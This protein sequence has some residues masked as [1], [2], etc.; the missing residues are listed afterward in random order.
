MEYKA[1]LKRSNSHTVEFQL[2]DELDIEEVK[3]H[4]HNGRIYAH[5]DFYD[6]D[7]I[8]N[9]QR[10]HLYAL[11]KDIEDYTGTPVDAVEAYQKYLFMQHEDLEELP[12][13]AR[14]KMT[15]VVA[16]HFLEF[17]IN[18]CI[19]NGI[20][21]RQQ[22][23]YLTMDTS[24]MLFALTMKRI[25]IKCGR[26]QAQI[27]HASNLVGMGNK[28]SKHNHIDSTFMALCSDC[29]REIHTTGY[30]EFCEKYYVQAIKLSAENIKELRL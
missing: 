26:P 14:G 22:K 9:D 21:F 23:F 5:I 16:S 19:E 20:A 7:T 11:F 13:L 17:T 28:R 1:I 4:A 6:K 15:K 29:H 18:Y 8:T 3:K 2:T 12:S 30:T 27:H 10:K 25:C 24:K